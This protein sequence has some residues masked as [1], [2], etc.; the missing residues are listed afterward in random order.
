MCDPRNES[1]GEK[2]YCDTGVGALVCTWESDLGW[3]GTASTGNL[4]LSATN[5]ELGARVTRGYVESNLS[6][7]VLVVAAR[8]G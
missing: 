7:R 1:R 8:V 4:D 6:I 3:V 2:T 5:I